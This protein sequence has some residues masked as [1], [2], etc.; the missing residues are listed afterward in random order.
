MG[1]GREGEYRWVCGEGKVGSCL[2]DLLLNDHATLNG[3]KY[4]SGNQPAER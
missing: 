1:G 3:P 4:E 2:E